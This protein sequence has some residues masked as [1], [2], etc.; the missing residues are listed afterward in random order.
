MAMTNFSRQ[1]PRPRMG[2]Q[3]QIKT[4]PWVDKTEDPESETK[5]TFFSLETLFETMTVVL[6]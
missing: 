1:R 6:I 3:N 2:I 5:N 4:A